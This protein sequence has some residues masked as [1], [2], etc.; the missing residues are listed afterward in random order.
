MSIKT[1]KTKKVKKIKA[2]CLVDKDTNEIFYYDNYEKNYWIYKTKT[3]KY[4]DLMSDTKVLP[5]E[6]TIKN[7]V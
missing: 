6:I 1:K 3:A 5:C 4:R 2:W 7:Y